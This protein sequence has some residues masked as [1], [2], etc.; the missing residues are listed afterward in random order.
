MVPTS[1]SSVMRSGQ[2]CGTGGSEDRG[3]VADRS[4]GLDFALGASR[5]G[6][7]DGGD[8][9]LDGTAKPNSVGAGGSQRSS[10]LPAAKPRI[11]SM[12]PTEPGGVIRHRLI[13]HSAGPHVWEFELPPGV[14]PNGDSR[15]DVV[16]LV[17]DKLAR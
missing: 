5:A 1:C 2:Q 8:V 14:H 16:F 4:R 9:D 11:R 7:R 13:G 3:A 17:A 10:P 12:Y 15:A 6:V